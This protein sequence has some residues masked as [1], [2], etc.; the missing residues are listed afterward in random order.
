MTFHA[1][2]FCSGIK[3]LEPPFI[4]THIVQYEVIAFGRMSV[5]Q[6]RWH[7]HTYPLAPV[8]SRKTKQQ[9]TFWYPEVF[10]IFCMALCPMQSSATIFITNILESSVMSTS[11]FCS[12]HSMMAVLGQLLRGRSVM[13]LLPFLKCTLSITYCWR[14]CKNL[15]RHDKNGERCFQQNCSPLRRIQWQNAGKMIHNLQS[16]CCSGLWVSIGVHA[17]DLYFTLQKTHIASWRITPRLIMSI[18]HT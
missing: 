7:T 4:T 1:L 8:S 18:K 6:L 5:K 10:L 16:L 13:F 3:M 12:L 17:L 15:D 11:T 9:Q 14:P 2:L